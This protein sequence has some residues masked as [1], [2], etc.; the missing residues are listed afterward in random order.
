MRIDFFFDPG[1]PWTWI[2][3]RWLLD[4]ASRRTDLDL[5]WRTFSLR[6]AALDE[7]DDGDPGDTASHRALRVV[8]AVWAEHGW[9]PIG[10]LYTALGT[11]V[12]H[13]GDPE[14]TRLPAALEHVG[15][16]PEFSADADALRW[17][18]EIRGSMADATAIVGDE[19]GLPVITIEDGDARPGLFGP[20]LSP[21]P[22]GAEADALFDAFLTAARSPGFFELKRT[23]DR[24][25]SLG[26]RP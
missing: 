24:S 19:V 16:D 6:M 17:D 8:E 9:D 22:V 15:L 21:A 1:C 13:N 23:R 3:S 7:E 11:L 2:S 10:P 14:L 25:P 20:V 12:H 26:P 5:R 18:A 4:V